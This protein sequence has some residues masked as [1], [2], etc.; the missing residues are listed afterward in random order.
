MQ[1]W[2]NRNSNPWQKY[3]YE[4]LSG[5]KGERGIALRNGDDWKLHRRIVNKTLMSKSLVNYI[6]STTLHKDPRVVESYLPI[7]NQKA[8]KL[9]RNIN[10][11]KG[12]VM[13]GSKEFSYY[14]TDTIAAISR[15]DF[16]ISQISKSC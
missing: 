2:Y 9:F 3:F 11:Q 5:L 12:E 16:S 1:D 8:K 15:N 6:I 4:N 14:T 13:N 7:I 10:N